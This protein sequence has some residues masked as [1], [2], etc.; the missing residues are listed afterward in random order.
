MAETFLPIKSVK[1]YLREFGYQAIVKDHQSKDVVRAQ[2]IDQF[3]KEIF[4]QLSVHVGDPQMLA[5]PVE[6]IDQKTMDKVNNILSNSVRKWR[7]LCIEFQKYAETVNTIFPSDLMVNLEDVV[8]GLTEP[9][10][11][12][13]KDAV[14]L[15]EDKAQ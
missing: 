6:E 7:R 1:Q 10:D 15:D 13:A 3:K 12:E 4:N 9:E 8:K 5:R 11:P 2:L 14:L